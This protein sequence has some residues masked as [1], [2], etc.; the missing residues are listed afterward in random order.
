MTKKIIIIIIFIIAIFSLILGFSFNYFTKKNN[1]DKKNTNSTNFNV[2][3]SLVIKACKEDN[4]KCHTNFLY[5]Q[6]THKIKN[7]ELQN[8]LQQINT[9]IK[10]KYNYSLSKK[11]D[12]NP[13]CSKVADKYNYYDVSA[14]DLS[15]YETANYI[16]IMYRPENYNLCTEK[17]SDEAPQVYIYS[18]EKQKIITQE[19]FQQELNITSDT[20]N[21]YITSATETLK[22]STNQ[23]YSYQYIYKNSKP[24]YML[25]YNYEGNLSLYYYQS[26]YDDYYTYVID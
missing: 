6:I 3:Y 24:E 5:P 25:F 12:D 7:E 2:D 1:Y 9:T 17:K 11:T 14:F 10:E 16:S 20:I 23:E 18:K 8:T 26:I 4:K 22:N 13:S 21:N 19:E 15:L